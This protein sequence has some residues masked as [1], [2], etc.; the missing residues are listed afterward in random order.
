[1]K[2]KHMKN[3]WMILLLVV[4]L[5]LTSCKKEIDQSQIEQTKIQ[6]YNDSVFTHLM[7][8]WKFKIPKPSKELAPILEEWKAWTALMNE[9]KLRPV[10]TIGAFQK[11]ATTLTEV[12]QN[13]TYQGYPIQL[14]TP[15]I[16]ARYS[17]L[18]T[19]FQNLEM[20]IDLDPVDIEQVDKW[21]NNIQLSLDDIVRMME[22]NLVRQNYVKEEGEATMLE[23]M[24]EFRNEMRRANPEEEE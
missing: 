21:L 5:S 17:T 13:L 9:L 10:S 1:M 2:F 12:A 4:G 18:L 8:E 22:E 6:Q 19:S 16:K 24:Q 3:I 23:D 14:D 20:F 15:D 7:K 11:K